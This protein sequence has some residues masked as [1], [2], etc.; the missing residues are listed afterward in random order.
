MSF[1]PSQSSLSLGVRRL[2]TAA[3]M[4][5]YARAASNAVRSFSEIPGPPLYPVVG[6]L[7]QVQSCEDV[8]KILA[9]IIIARL[10]QLKKILSNCLLSFQ[11]VIGPFSKTK[12]H[13]ALASLHR[14]YG[15][16][17]RENIGGRVIVHVFDPEDIKVGLSQCQ[18][19]ST[20]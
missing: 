3:A 7:Y 12:Y 10:M 18:T 15:P 13:E 11:Y 4:S 17:V 8:K 19:S 5:T 1:L 16:V 6:N 9:D 14:D 20:V 2:S